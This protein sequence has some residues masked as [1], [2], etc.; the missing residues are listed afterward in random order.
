MP[1]KVLGTKDGVGTPENVAKAIRYAEAQGASVCNLSFGT[2]KFN[3]ELYDTMKN[4]GMLF[5]VAAG[6]GD[7]E[8]KGVNL[9]EKPVY[10]LPLTWKI[11]FLW[12]VCVWTE[13]WS[14]LELRGR[15][16][17]SG[18]AWKIYFEHH[19]RRPVC[20]HERDFHGRRPWCLE[21]LPL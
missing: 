20:L 12:P 19:F 8:G 9:D 7:K 17:G 15:L 11:L 1:L 16:C 14:Q 13:I 3:Q 10:R 21:P 2:G 6:N 4:S 5:V 18:R